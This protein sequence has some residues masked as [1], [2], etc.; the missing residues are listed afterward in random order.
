VS[1][2]VVGV[3]GI[4]QQQVGRHQLRAPWSRALADGLER[5]TGARIEV[6]DLDVAFFGDVFLQGGA[7][8]VKGD[9]VQ[10]RLADID[11]ADVALVLAA[12]D[13]VLTESDMVAAAKAPA[14]GFPG[15]PAPVLAVIA[16]VDRRFGAHA[17]PLFVG[18]L[19]QVRRYLTDTDLKRV[20]DVRVAKA[21]DASTRVVIGHSLGSVVA[22][23]HLRLY[24]ANHIE[25]LVTLGSPL[26]LRAIRQLLPDP[27]FGTGPD[28]PANAGRWVNL[29][30]RRD[31]VALAGDLRS[32]W[33][34]VEDD[35]TLD[36]GRS[37][38]AA[39]R[40]LGK[41]QT[42][43]AVRWALTTPSSRATSPENT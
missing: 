22:L 14:K 35:D 10:V 2:V 39:E 15:L 17:G 34:V 16:A 20:V 19:S 41:R 33:P 36:N 6:P 24:P 18:E 32:W 5:A 8:G 43:A 9:E 1:A 28:G 29:R 26:G 42:G 12:A 3:H 30:D 11:D 23:E 37:P 7:D 31:P 21:V 4:A 40:Y 13:E 25:L 38:H 27:G